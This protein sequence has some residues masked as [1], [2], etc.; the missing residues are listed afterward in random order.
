MKKLLGLLGGLFAAKAKA[1]PISDPIADLDE[2]LRTE[3]PEVYAGLNPGV[4]A[5]ALDAFEAEFNVVL[6]AMFRRLY[7]W[8]NGHGDYVPPSMVL[9]LQFP[10]LEA[11]AKTKEMLD[12]MIGYDFPDSGFWERA[13]VPF[14]E[15]GGG[16]NLVVVADGTQ[17]GGAVLMFYHDD[18]MRT[19]QAQSL[20]EWVAMVARGEEPIG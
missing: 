2:W 3:R 17:T 12:G 18:P 8:R 19:T 4:D 16:D 5:A 20:A 15:N 6:P 7:E 13:W 14:M 11:V 9:N 1:D 10:P